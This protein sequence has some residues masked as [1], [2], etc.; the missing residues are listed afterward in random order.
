MVEAIRLMFCDYCCKYSPFILPLFVGVG[1]E[2]NE[3]PKFTTK[4]INGK[5]EFVEMDVG[6]Y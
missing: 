6:T 3:G 4:P 5:L 2:V 1:V